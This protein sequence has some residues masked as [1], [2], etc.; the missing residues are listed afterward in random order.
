MRPGTQ[1]KWVML[2]DFEDYMKKNG[3]I[4]SLKL[5]GYCIEGDVQ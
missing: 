1:I 2:R 5:I 4:A 3:D